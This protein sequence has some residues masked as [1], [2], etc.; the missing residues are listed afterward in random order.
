MEILGKMARSY[1]NSMCK[2]AEKTN[3]QTKPALCVCTETYFLFK[4]PEGTTQN[5]VMH[6]MHLGPFLVE[7]REE[8]GE[9][10]RITLTVGLN[11]KMLFQ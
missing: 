11:L 4:T 9:V 10:C 6:P 3:K 2:Q 1:V 5:A 7:V 8:A